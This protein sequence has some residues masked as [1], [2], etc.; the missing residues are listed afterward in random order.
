MRVGIIWIAPLVLAGFIGGQASPGGC[1]VYSRCEIGVSVL[2]ICF[3]FYLGRSFS[4]DFERALAG[5]RRSEVVVGVGRKVHVLG[6]VQLQ[7]D[8]CGY[9]V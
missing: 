8:A 7:G 6:D 1:G 9:G 3:G 2:A 5:L 4:D